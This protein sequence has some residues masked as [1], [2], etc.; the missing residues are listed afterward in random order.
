LG[1]SGIDLPIMNILP[2]SRIIQGVLL[3][4]IFLKLSG[5]IFKFYQ[6]IIPCSSYKYT[7]E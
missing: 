4:G 1:F 5:Y 2:G 3:V 7:V 6:E